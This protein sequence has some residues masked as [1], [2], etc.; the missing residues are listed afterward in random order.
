MC[1]YVIL[2]SVKRF[3]L[4][5]VNYPDFNIYDLFIVLE[6]YSPG[7]LQPFANLIAY[8]KRFEVSYLTI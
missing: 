5:Q 7:C 6:T 4:F 2:T 1:T 3:I 8:V